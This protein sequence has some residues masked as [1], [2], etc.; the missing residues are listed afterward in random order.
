[1]IDNLR[2]ELKKLDTLKDKKIVVIL[3]SSI[4]HQDVLDTLK[5]ME[6]EYIESEKLEKYCGMDVDFTLIDDYNCRPEDTKPFIKKYRSKSDRKRN[7]RDR[8][9]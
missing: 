6:I 8:W 2:E 5:G 7:K 3:G 9:K 4:I 1:M